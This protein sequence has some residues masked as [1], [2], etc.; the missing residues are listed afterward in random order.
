MS[1]KN[2]VKLCGVSSIISAFAYIGTVIFS[3]V[4]GV[5][6]PENL[7]GMAAFLQNWYDARVLMSA[8]GWFGILGSLFTLP[9]IVGMY[10]VLRKQAP[11]QWAPIAII[12]HGVLLLT[13]AYTIPLV[14][15]FNLAPRFVTET[16]PELLSSIMVT[17]EVLRTIEDVCVK[18][19]T[20]LT[21]LTGISIMAIIDWKESRF[22][23][24]IN[25]LAIVTGIISLSFLGTFT[26]TGI[27]YTIFNITS[28]VS[29]GL[30]LLW[31][32]AI[33]IVMILPMKAV[34][35]EEE[36]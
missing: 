28:I 30:M 33:G 7:T 16:Q 36:K 23:R 22:P 2:F 15:S 10:Q 18:V 25:I 20:I 31:M 14:I 17:T 27:V 19:G 29:L 3:S 35:S 11:W 24:G 1:E 34:E 21:L 26:T 13:I 8:Y 4:A 6:N 32:I 5:V 12:F 9:L